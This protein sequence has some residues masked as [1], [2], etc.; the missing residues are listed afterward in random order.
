[1]DKVDGFQTKMNQMLKKNKMHNCE[2]PNRSV[3]G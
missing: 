1:M 3:A 2:V